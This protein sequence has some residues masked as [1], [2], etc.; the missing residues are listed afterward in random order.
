MSIRGP[1]KAFKTVS[2]DTPYSEAQFKTLKYRPDFPEQFGSLAD[3]RHWLRPFF[4]WY[5][6][7]PY[8]TA[9]GLLTPASVHYGQ[10]E[11]IRDQRQQVL[12]AAYAAHPDRFVRGLPIPPDLPTEVWINRPDNN[13]HLLDGLTDLF[14]TEPASDHPLPDPLTTTV[15]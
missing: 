13:L 11:A 9:L 3:G 2:N 12:Q 15:P 1:W 5:N 8:H 7:D 10:A 14:L 4:H 6:H